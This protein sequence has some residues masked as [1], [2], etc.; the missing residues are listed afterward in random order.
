MIRTRKKKGVRRKTRR[1]RGGSYDLP[2][3]A[4]AFWDSETPPKSIAAILKHRPAKMPGWESI[5]L[6]QSTIGEHIDPTSYPKGFDA[7]KPQHKADWIRLSLL[8]KY[9]GVWLDAGIIINDIYEMDTIHQRMLNEMPEATLFFLDHHGHTDTIP[10]YIDNWFIMAPKGSPLIR[11]WKKEYEIAIELGL[12]EYKKRYLI[13]SPIKFVMFNE[14]LGDVYLLCQAILQKILQSAQPKPKLI[15]LSPG[16]TMFK[17][18][19]TCSGRA[20]RKPEE[21]TKCVQHA[22]LTDP[23]SKKL[24]Y[25]KLRGPN[26]EN[27]DLNSYFQPGI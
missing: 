9:G 16:N 22:L 24:P 11:N 6:S 13:N 4:W 3:K 14:H 21:N 26:R 12:V 20:N 7:L 8:E 23:A 5:H 18:H 27:L 15:F 19:A 2:K 25:I 1:Q 10:L 17:I